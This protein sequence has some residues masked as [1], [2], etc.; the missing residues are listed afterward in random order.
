MII[1]LLAI[2]LIGLILIVALFLPKTSLKVPFYSVIE[3][4]I[5][6]SQIQTDP[7]PIRKSTY[8]KLPP[9][10]AR[11]A[12]VIDA[13]TGSSL[14][15]KNPHLK[16]LPAS[17]TKLM[18][19]LVTLEKCLP[20]QVVTVDQIEKEG[21]QMGLEVGDQV[22]V[23][24]LLYGLLINS[25]NDAAYTLASACS[26]SANHFVLAMNQKAED[27]GL[28][29]THFTNPTGFDDN[30]QYST[31]FDLAKLA[32]IAIANPLIAKIVA[33]KSTVVTDVTGNK[34]YFLDNVNEL[35]GVVDGIEG[36]KTGQTEG[37]LENLITKTTR[38]GNSIVIA[39][40]GS[41]DRFA[42]TR[43]LIKWAFG[44]F[45]WLTF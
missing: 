37:A 9:I 12:V 13:K 38:N 36:V 6:A 29:N 39:L 19:A 11:S 30:Y 18:T 33:T 43:E 27:L 31:A 17:T 22:S 5:Q 1:R 20:T 14:F 44:Q 4:K 40:L 26:N 35:L 7:F 24:N 42:E 34:A 8:Q 25:G 10:S 45:E 41:K 16:H 15:E 3:E 23:E 21:T 2:I 28:T 32:N